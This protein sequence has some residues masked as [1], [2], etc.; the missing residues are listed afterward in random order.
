MSNYPY[1]LQRNTISMEISLNW[2]SSIIVYTTF[3][4]AVSSFACKK[5]NKWIYYIACRLLWQVRSSYSQ[6]RRTLL[7]YHLQKAVARDSTLFLVRFGNN[8]LII[9]C[10]L[11][12]VT[13]WK[14]NEQKLFTFIRRLSHI[15]CI[16]IC[17]DGSISKQY[18]TVQFLGTR[19]RAK[20][21][22]KKKK[23]LIIIIKK[24]N[25]FMY[26]NMYRENR[27][28]RIS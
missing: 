15:V 7:R 18:R 5:R 9:I 28:I 13:L 24:K 1:R 27:S 19:T 12:T 10:I 25:G 6:K 4:T 23:N 22:K 17:T 20:I 16:Y 11:V 3:F 2:S 8:E 26:V 14:T 21:V